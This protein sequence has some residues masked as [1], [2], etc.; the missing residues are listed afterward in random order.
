MTAPRGPRT[1]FSRGPRPAGNQ[2]PGSFLSEIFE[3]KHFREWSHGPRWPGMGGAGRLGAG[4]AG[5]AGGGGGRRTGAAGMVGGLAAG[6][7]SWTWPDGGQA[8]AG[9][10]RDYSLHRAIQV[11]SSFRLLLA[12]ATAQGQSPQRELDNRAAAAA[13]P[14]PSPP[15][16][17]SP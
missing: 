15:R 10:R 7:S 17:A 1:G 5:V 14:R 12:A 16:P 6:G 2:G 9:R 8:G 3:L 11:S 13:P 4:G